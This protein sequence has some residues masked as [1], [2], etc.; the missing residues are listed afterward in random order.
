MHPTYQIYILDLQFYCASPP[1][2]GVYSCVRSLFA[3][4]IDE[5][6]YVVYTD[7]M[8]NADTCMYRDICHRYVYV[9]Y[10]QRQRTWGGRGGGGGG[11]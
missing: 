7:A 3:T 5:C 2:L 1:F 11:A 6:I 10:L 9:F 8:W 4:K